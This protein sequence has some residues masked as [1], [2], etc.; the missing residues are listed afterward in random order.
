MA[1]DLA[2]PR[3]EEG[4]HDACA[5][6]GPGDL[7]LLTA[8][9]AGGD[10]QLRDIVARAVRTRLTSRLR[11]SPLGPWHAGDL[12]RLHYDEVVATWYGG[13][14]TVSMVQAWAA[15]AARAWEEDGVSKWM[16]YDRA[17]GSLIGRGGL[18]W[19]HVGGRRR[20][21]VG[22][23]VRGDLWGHGY[24]TEIG[25]AAL[26]FASAELGAAE[27]VAFTEA[28]NKRSRAMMERL[29]MRY[30]RAISHDNARFVLYE[31]RPL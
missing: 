12:W 23:T 9:R 16:A 25:R 26:D 4:K 29:G 18:S 1:G 19:K 27:V 30:A 20:L 7:D 8:G 17:S 15:Q 31:I 11:L 10:R 28:G 14:R 22:W 21:E 3:L 5:W 6:A 2:A 13:R 24:A